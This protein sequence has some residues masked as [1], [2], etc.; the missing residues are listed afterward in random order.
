MFSFILIIIFIIILINLSNEIKNLRKEVRYL[1]SE[2][3]EFSNFK[4]KIDGQL[5]K[6]SSVREELEKVELENEEMQK[7]V[8]ETEKGEVIKEEIIE[9]KKKEKVDVTAAGI[10]DKTSIAIEV[11]EEAD[12]E[13]ESDTTVDNIEEQTIV[14]TKEEVNNLQDSSKEDYWKQFAV[15]EEEDNHLDDNIKSDTSVEQRLN[16]LDEEVK[17]ERA[18]R[19]K[20]FKEMLRGKVIEPFDR[21]I[22]SKRSKF[23]FEKML[24]FEYWLNKIG[25]GLLLLGIIF[26]FKY[27]L[28]QGWVTPQIKVG[29]G[30]AIGITLEVIGLRVYSKRARFGQVLIGGGIA[31][32]YASGFAA[33]QL[34][35]IVPYLLA[36]VFMLAVTLYAY[37]LSIRQEEVVLALIGFVGGVGT[38]FL[39]YSGEGSLVNL[40]LYL[41]FIVGGTSLVYLYKGWPLLLWVSVLGG[42]PLISLGLIGDISYAERRAVQVAIVF[43]WLIYW[44]IPVLREV[45]WSKNKNKW[46]KPSL[47]FLKD[48]LSEDMMAFVNRHV[49]LLVIITPLI[50]LLY[51][52]KLWKVGYRIWDLGNSSLRWG[53]IALA[54]SVVYQAVAFILKKI[55]VKEKLEYVHILMAFVLLTMTLIILVEGNTLIAALALETTAL[56]LVSIKLKDKIM[57]LMSHLIF[58]VVAIWLGLRLAMNDLIGLPILNTQAIVDIVIIICGLVTTKNIKDKRVSQIYKLFFG[59]LAI[60]TLLWRELSPVPNGYH[61]IAIAWAA[62]A[63]AEYIIAKKY[64]NKLLKN[65][66]HLVFGALLLWRG[67]WFITETVNGMVVFNMQSLADIIIIAV[68]FIMSSLDNV[69]SKNNTLYKI[70][71]YLAAFGLA[72][73][74]LSALPGY[75]YVM[76]AWV[77]EAVIIHILAY[78]DSDRFMTLS[79]HYVFMILGVILGYRLIRGFSYYY[80]TTPVFNLTAL[81]DLLIITSALGIS[82]IIK[83]EEK[84]LYRV[85]ALVMILGW[86]FR[87]LSILAYNYVL[88]AWLIE[89]LIVH[90]IAKSKNYN[91][92]KLTA[93]LTFILMALWVGLRITLGWDSLSLISIGSIVNLLIIASAVYIS[94]KLNSVDKRYYLV[95]ANLLFLAWLFRGLITFGYSYIM[96]AWTVEAIIVHLIAKKKKLNYLNDF[97]HLVFAILGIWIVARA[98]S[99]ISGYLPALSFGVLTDFIILVSIA[100]VGKKIVEKRMKNLYLLLSH[101]L[102][103]LCSYQFLSNFIRGYE[104]TMLVWVIEA[105]ILYIIAKR[106]D[107]FDLE[108]GADFVFGALALWISAR[109]FLNLV[110]YPILNFAVITEAIVIALIGGTIKLYGKEIELKYYKLLSALLLAGIF[111]REFEGLHNGYSYIIIS[112][113]ILGL[114]LHFDAKRSLDLTA[115]FSSQVVFAI[116]AVWVV[117]RIFKIRLGVPILNIM[118]LADILVIL[119]IAIYAYFESDKTK[120]LVYGFFSYLSMLILLYKEFVHLANGQGSVTVAWGIYAISI[121]LFGLRLDKRLFIGT[122]VATLFVVVG[123]LFMIDLANVEAIWKILLFIG[124]GVVFLVI[125]YY[126]QILWKPKL[127]EDEM[128]EQ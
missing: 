26:L 6:E 42:W 121:L 31:A 19:M 104:Y 65:A 43:F 124:F 128:I 52:M 116:L 98:S 76:I 71:S 18:D 107:N 14:K 61:L 95:G 60:L 96:L 100:L 75:N 77:L 33:F 123:K 35:E 122:A 91:Y 15:K 92:L 21:A 45:L 16:Q 17:Q 68:G 89:G 97:S 94:K 113:T 36:F 101:I 126:L 78:R 84:I 57:N 46:S 99:R 83:R 34:Y 9:D 37:Y 110:D 4:E 85:I 22:W 119:C 103:L 81:V 80:L 38:P 112:W 51:S 41:C 56:I 109:I 53:G 118:A 115:K 82:K 8:D 28:N 120:A 11:E 105:T 127:D 88:L 2:V 5:L 87:E 27:S 66:S 44:I 62:E 86:L 10:E 73:R 40:M 59:H 30:L 54:G 64:D 25:I 13:E 114:L 24:S 69:K 55:K 47:D 102:F 49:N 12:T 48:H 39:L 90:L 72:W 1:K 7:A 63:L 93:H 125:S 32:L 3:I 70:G 108:V 106:K 20:K 23:D 58:V 67:Y 117:Y 74:E 111:Y 79:A 29:I 50:S